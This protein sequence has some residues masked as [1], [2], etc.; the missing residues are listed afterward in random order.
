[1]ILILSAKVL[2]QEHHVFL[3]LL[4]GMIFLKLVMHP[5]QVLVLVMDQ[6]MM[7][8]IQTVK[9]RTLKNVESSLK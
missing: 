1:M 3:F 2:A 6:D 4:D 8:M 5:M 7:M 9:K